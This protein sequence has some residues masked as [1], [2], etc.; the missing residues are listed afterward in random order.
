MSRCDVRQPPATAGFTLLEVMVSVALM[1]VVM[2][3]GGTFMMR[4]MGTSGTLIG[5]Q[6]AITVANQVLESVRA[7]DATFDSAGVSPLVHGRSR[8]LVIA[9][10]ASAA[11]AGV[12]IADTYVGQ[13]ATEY[14]AAVYDPGGN[15][16]QV[17]LV[18]TVPL[19]AR[20]LEA[21]VLIGA[22][23]MNESTGVCAKT[24][25]GTVMLRVI[26]VVSWNGAAGGCPALGC[27][28]LSSTLLD[29]SP[30]P[31][32][33]SG[34]RPVANP[35]SVTTRVGAAVD[36]AV[37]FND[38]GVFAVTGAVTSISTPTRGTVTTTG[39][40]NTLTY[41]PTAGF[42]GTD[43]FSYKVLDTSNRVSDAAVV[44]IVVTP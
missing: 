37:T 25:A 27:S 1:S 11:A 36:I 30:D 31:Q 6:A 38:S 39:S 2:A 42:V 23:A 32:F 3:M 40:S 10:W 9:Q 16:L 44:T 7:V 14:D 19:G 12:D 17:P 5:R 29:P 28:Y 34:R 41:R 8:D 15:Q 26:V 21:E 35:D 33:N 18:R 4:A 20:T 43:S 24:G 13:G 22:C